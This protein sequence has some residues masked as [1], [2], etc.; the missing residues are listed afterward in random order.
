MSV[1]KKLR[2]DSEASLQIE[3]QA[4]IKIALEAQ[5]ETIIQICPILVSFDD[6]RQIGS[7]ESDVP[8][9]RHDDWKDVRLWLTFFLGLA[10]YSFFKLKLYRTVARYLKGTFQR[11]AFVKLLIISS[12]MLT[13]FS[14]FLFVWSL[15]KH[16]IIVQPLA[17]ISK[18]SDVPEDL[19]ITQQDVFG[20]FDN[21]K[22]NIQLPVEIDTSQPGNPDNLNRKTTQSHYDDYAKIKIRLRNDVSPALS[23]PNGEMAMEREY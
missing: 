2:L 1:G 12:M 17:T 23:L 8:P 5:V 21:E 4:H 7:A 14:S 9:M 22:E 20:D 3:T 15:Q 10:S 19:Y 6:D 18:I 13:V 11:N 16:A